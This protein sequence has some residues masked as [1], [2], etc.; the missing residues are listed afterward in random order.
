[1][2]SLTGL[3]YKN[4]FYVQLKKCQMSLAKINLKYPEDTIDKLCKLKD[5]CQKR[6]NFPKI[7]YKTSYNIYLKRT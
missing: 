2:N 3:E 1:M 7:L 5:N 4:K 6:Y